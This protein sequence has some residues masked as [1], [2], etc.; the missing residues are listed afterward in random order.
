MERTGI[1]VAGKFPG[2]WPMTREQLQRE[3]RLRQSE[4]DW[5][6]ERGRGDSFRVWIWGLLVGACSVG[7]WWAVVTLIR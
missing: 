1:E 7:L 3:A 2:L 5:A 6:Y 4:L